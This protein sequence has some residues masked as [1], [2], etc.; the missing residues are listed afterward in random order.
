[1]CNSCRHQCHQTRFEFATIVRDD[2]IRDGQRLGVQ[3]QIP[4]GS[5]EAVLENLEI[6]ARTAQYIAQSRPSQVPAQVGQLPGPAH[7][8]YAIKTPVNDVP[9]DRKVSLLY[10]IDKFTRALDPRPPAPQ[11]RGAPRCGAP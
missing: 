5:V 11:E 9:L 3:T 7:D 6:A 1:M 4:L 8:L 2:L 10:E